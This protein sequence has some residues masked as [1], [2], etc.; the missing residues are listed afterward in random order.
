MSE[1]L[2]AIRNVKAAFPD[3]EVVGLNA[4]DDK[5][6]PPEGSGTVRFATEEM[7]K[8]RRMAAE[9]LKHWD[10]SNQQHFWGGRS[11]LSACL[12]GFLGEWTVSKLLGKPGPEARRTRDRGIDID[13]GDMTGQV[14]LRRAKHRYFGIGA[15]TFKAD[16]G[17][18]VVPDKTYRFIFHATKWVTREAFDLLK[19]RIDFGHGLHHVID[20]GHMAPWDTLPPLL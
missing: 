10:N 8:A 16:L 18:L 15:T 14:K 1:L 20:E 2:D 3:A 17:I 7:K 19:Q 13:L 9:Q 11:P 12:D 5:T 6:F 4:P